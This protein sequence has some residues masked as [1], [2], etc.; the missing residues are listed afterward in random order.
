[1]AKTDIGNCELQK[2]CEILFHSRN[3]CLGST[4]KR[5]LNKTKNRPLPKTLMYGMIIS[6]E[7]PGIPTEQFLKKAVNLYTT[8]KTYKISLNKKYQ[9]LIIL[10]SFYHISQEV[11]HT[12]R[13]LPFFH[14]NLTVESWTE[15]SHLCNKSMT[16]VRH[17]HHIKYIFFY[18]PI[19][20]IYKMIKLNLRNIQIK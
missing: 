20:K 17:S 6:I 4:I 10:V 7:G 2:L 16:R 15:N 13:Y 19:T 9:Q 1:M 3:N 18:C 14:R 5:T 12:F 11:S 8:K